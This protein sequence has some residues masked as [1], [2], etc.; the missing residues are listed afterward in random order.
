V[1]LERGS[2]VTG[3][4]RLERPL[5]QGAMGCVWVARHL[6]L[7]V[8]VA[9]KL[10]APGFAESDEARIR[11]ERE[12]K[13]SALLKVPNAVHVYD[14]GIEAGS[15]FLVMELLEGEDLAARLRRHGRLS[16][17][18]TLAVLE[19]VGK[20]L[21]RA[22][23]LGLV[24]RDLK[25]GNIF[26]ARHGDEEIVKV[27]DFGI[28]KAAAGL[29]LDAHATRSGALLGSPRYMS[30]E[31]VRH[32]NHLD[33]RSDL[34]ALGVIAF[35][36]VTGQVPFPGDEI[37]EVLV[38][39]CT[40]PIPRASAVA[41][42]LGPEVD[43]FFDRALMRDPEQRFQSASELVEAFAALTSRSASAAHIGPDNAPP[44]MGAPAAPVVA[45]PAPSSGAALGAPQPA[46]GTL[47]PSEHTQSPLSQ[48]SRGGTAAIAVA[49][50][51]GGAA[52]LGT[53]LFLVAR[54]PSAGPAPA[55][56]AESH[57]LPSAAV[58]APVTAPP[59]SSAVASA[60]PAL[61]A[62]PSPG[63]ST[64][65]GARPRSPVRSGPTTT[66]PPKK[67]NDLLEHM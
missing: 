37:G 25:P 20:A 10:M 12:A 42:D 58:S 26:L 4:Y 51:L 65:S 2:I 45:S 61:S 7:D 46:I 60:P 1:Q 50:A 18:A 9:I 63:A 23:E 49:S 43:G 48:A 15:P 36:C 33:H 54:G 41:P 8:D 38:D 30:P 16:L 44:P 31:Q 55:L 64:S 67:K 27:V 5:A 24:H 28:A 56:S 32:S 59:A 52:V 22:R 66:A 19:P 62:A 29:G 14:Y 6:Q 11:F 13:A 3:R 34:W 21:R 39:V 17:A 57:A 35:E 40:A 53:I 47:S